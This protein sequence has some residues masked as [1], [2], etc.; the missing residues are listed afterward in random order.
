MKIIQGKSY[1][2]GIYNIQ[3]KPVDILTRYNKST[4]ILRLLLV[5]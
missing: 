4:I 1:W 3:I 2:H 5:S